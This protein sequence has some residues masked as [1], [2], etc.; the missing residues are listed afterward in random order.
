MPRPGSAYGARIG[1]YTAS[2]DAR[3]A[4]RLM[5]SLL[6]ERG[7]DGP[8][9][10]VAELAGPLFAPVAP[11][12]AVTIELDGGGGKFTVFTGEVYASTA[13]ATG[14]RVHA[15]DA[16][17]K[18]ATTEVERAYESSRADFIA[19]D[20]IARADAVAGTIAPGPLFDTY[21]VHRQPR[22]LR[23]LGTL[24]ALSGADVWTDGGGKVQLGLPKT[25]GGDHC[26]TL[27]EDIL[28]L[29]LHAAPPAMDGVE[30][31]G[32]GA[33]DAKGAP[34]AHWL[35]TDLEGIAAKAAVGTEG[36]VR[37][38]GTG[39]RPQRRTEGALRSR[40]SV[41]GFA[42]A[43]ARSRA[44]R[45][46]RGCIEVV[47]A[48]EVEPGDLVVIRGLAPEHGAAR[49]LEGGRTLRVRT[50]RHV[51]D[52]ARGFRTRLEF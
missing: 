25:G 9:R 46:V 19:R 28:L 6:V 22:A 48:P 33:A 2:S 11:G 5:P 4:D 41:K 49:L 24:A 51:L 3:H 39:T 37:E 40:E 14:Q 32:E 50:L 13:T 17:A 18:L 27:G 47:G 26:F 42:A 30:V 10:C 31:W 44:A 35:S 29:D 8:G 36:E 43:W 34:A 16:L 23:H 52:R 21:V 12:E 7:M 45:L 38:G 1:G 15:A 20:L